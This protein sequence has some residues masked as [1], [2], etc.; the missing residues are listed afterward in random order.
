M[1]LAT[2]YKN[3]VL[4]KSLGEVLELDSQMGAPDMMEISLTPIHTLSA[5]N[6]RR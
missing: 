5:S 2:V 1:S 3:I 6:A 4:I